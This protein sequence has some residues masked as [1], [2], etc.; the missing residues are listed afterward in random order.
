M[1]TQTHTSDY[2]PLREPRATL[3]EVRVSTT[4]TVALQLP[5]VN[6]NRSSR[7]SSS[8]PEAAAAVEHGRKELCIKTVTN[9]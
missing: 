8:Q 2:R 7:S 6:Q 5:T 1:H 9:P 4:P 3:R